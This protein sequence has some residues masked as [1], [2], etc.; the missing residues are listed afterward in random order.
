VRND[1]DVRQTEILTA[2]PLATG[3]SHLEAE[4]AI[5]K[6]KK[7]ESLGSDKIPAELI[8]TRRVTLLSEIYKFINSV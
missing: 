5:A 2:A 1:S 7:Y 6:L 8:Q 4:I 3:P